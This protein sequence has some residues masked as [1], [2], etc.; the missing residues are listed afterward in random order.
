MGSFKSLSLKKN[1]LQV[2]AVVCVVFA[3][4]APGRLQNGPSD[5]LDVLWCSRDLW[6]SSS[7][8]RHTSRFPEVL[9][10]QQNGFSVRYSVPRGDLVVSTECTLYRYDRVTAK[11]RFRRQM[12]AARWTTPSLRLQS[13][14]TGTSQLPAPFEP[15]SI[16]LRPPLPSQ[17]LTEIREDILPH[18][19]IMSP[20][21]FQ[22][23]NCLGGGG[24]VL[25][26]LYASKYSI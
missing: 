8:F 9:N 15:N 17:C 22:M 16:L 13:V 1:I 24:M 23:P 21:I 20:I 2:V 14:V 12:R 19:V 7:F 10:P 6:S 11:S 5:S 18:P 25:H 26:V 3:C 4:K